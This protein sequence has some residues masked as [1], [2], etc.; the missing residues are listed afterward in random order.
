MKALELADRYDVELRN[1]MQDTLN[2]TYKRPRKKYASW[3]LLDCHD[4]LDFYA[5]IGRERFKEAF[6]KLRTLSKK[7]GLISSKL[8]KVLWK[9]AEIEG[10][11]SCLSD[12]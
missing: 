2:L 5:L 8:D 1:E 12:S 6:K 3:T 9:L 4:V 10:Y 7:H 11:V